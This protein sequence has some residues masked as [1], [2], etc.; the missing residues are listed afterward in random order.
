MWQVWNYESLE[1]VHILGTGEFSAKVACVAFS[2][3]DED[4][5]SKLAVV[6]GAE[7]PNI[8]VWTGGNIQQSKNI[9]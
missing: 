7:Q 1:L 9:L 6:D 8:S 5:G 2:I 3:L 4:G